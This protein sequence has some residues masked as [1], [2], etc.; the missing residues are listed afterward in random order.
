MIAAIREVH[1]QYLFRGG[2]GLIFATN[3]PNL[4]V[5]RTANPEQLLNEV[6]RQLQAGAP[7]YGN[8]MKVFG[9]YGGEAAVYKYIRGRS[10]E[11]THADLIGAYERGEI[12]AVEFAGCVQ[13]LGAD[14][15]AGIAQLHVH[16]VVHGDVKAN[17]VVLGHLR[18]RAHLVD[19]SAIPFGGKV[20][21]GNPYL[22]RSPEV[23]AAVPPGW[24]TAGTGR[25]EQPVWTPAE[26]NMV[27]LA[28]GQTVQLLHDPEDENLPKADPAD[29]GDG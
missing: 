4:V 29:P 21:T 1:D 11:T 6:T 2:S 14:V 26:R 17:N 5:K 24:L 27:E 19:F 28:L 7:R 15:M 9:N 8:L 16:K 22:G 12:N 3:V 10:L 20:E 23:A 25:L 18:S 13:R